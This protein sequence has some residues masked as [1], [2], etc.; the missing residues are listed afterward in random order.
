M[1]DEDIYDNMHSLG[2]WIDDILSR[3]IRALLFL[4]KPGKASGARAN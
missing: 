3:G 1:R 4:F 2:S